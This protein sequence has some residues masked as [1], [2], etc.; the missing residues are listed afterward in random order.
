MTLVNKDF[1]YTAIDRFPSVKRDLTVLVD[2]SVIFEDFLK[3][4]YDNAEDIVKEIKLIDVYEN[5][6]LGA[7]KRSITIQIVMR[8]DR[9]LTDEEAK[10]AVD[11][12]NM[13][14]TGKYN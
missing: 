5:E 8:A 11:K 2:K 7:D 13:A 4:A 9:T 1:K 6:K 12:I 14:L 3:V 10:E